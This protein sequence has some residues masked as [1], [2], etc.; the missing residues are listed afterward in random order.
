MRSLPTLAD[1][2]RLAGVST[3]TVSRCLNEPE[4]VASETRQRVV[5]S[6]EELGYTPNFGGKAL[7]SRQINTV[8]AVI[9]TMDNAIFA[10]GLQAFQEELSSN[11]LTLLVASSGYDP[12]REFAQIRA[13]VGRGAD[14][15]LLI[16][17]QRP[18]SSYDFLSRRR[19][20]FVIAWAYRKTRTMSHAGFDNRR[21]AMQ[22]TERVIAAGHRH[23]AVIAGVTKGNDRASDRLQGVR[24]TLNAR[25]LDATTMPVIETHYSLKKGA[26]ALAELMRI[27]PRPTAVICGNDVLA[28][29]AVIQAKKLGLRV[30]DNVS[31]TGFDNI[32][33]ASV[34]EPKLTTVHV[35]HRRMG[36]AAAQ[37]LLGMRQEPSKIQSCEFATEIVERDSLGPPPG[38]SQT[39]LM[40]PSTTSSTSN[41][42]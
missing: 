42:I 27:S 12:I 16:G 24:D 21:A 10:R 26:H 34:S 6:I 36:K 31:I 19:I 17:R 2:A 8:G 33:L 25:G 22:M 18:K 9:P 35:P 14:G 5:R 7:A 32:E 20:P 23:I 15:L 1:V 39:T 40:P 3:A 30:P 4:K 41:A 28:A 38:E 37:L 11:G 29:G 13:L